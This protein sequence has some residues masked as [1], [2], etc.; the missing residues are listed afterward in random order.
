MGGPCVRGLLFV[1]KERAIDTSDV[2]WCVLDVFEEWGDLKT[3]MG[4]I[5]R[6]LGPEVAHA[7]GGQ[8]LCMGS[9]RVGKFR[10]GSAS[11]HVCRPDE[12][13]D[14]VDGILQSRMLAA[15]SKLVGLQWGRG[16]EAGCPPTGLSTSMRGQPPCGQPAGRTDCGQTE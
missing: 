6:H 13:Y 11:T 15:C 16:W 10:D 5:W 8:C 3:G 4:Y 12:D 1:A 2:T 14:T 9:R 7:V